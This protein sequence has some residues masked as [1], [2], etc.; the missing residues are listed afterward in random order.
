V[1]ELRID[2][3]FP[4]T[5]SFVRVDRLAFAIRWTREHTISLLV[6]HRVEQLVNEAQKNVAGVQITFADRGGMTR[7]LELRMTNEAKVTDWVIGLEALLAVVPRS[8]TKSHWQWALLCMVPTSERGSKDFIPRSN[9]RLVLARAHARNSLNTRVLEEAYRAAE[10]RNAE[11]PRWLRATRHGEGRRQKLLDVWQVT[12][13]LIELCTQSQQINEL[14]DRHAV[15]NVG[16]LKW[17]EF[18]RAEQVRG[19]VDEIQSDVGKRNE[20][21]ILKAKRV[22]PLSRLD[23]ALL[24]L[25]PDNDAVV[26]EL[27]PETADEQDA[28]LAHYW[29]ACSHNSYLV[30]DQLTGLS[31]ADAYRRQLLQRCRSLEIDCWD[32]RHGPIVTHGHTFCTV[33]KFEE[34]AKAIGECAFITSDLPVILSMEMHC[35]PEQQGQLTEMLLEHVGDRILP[36]GELTVAGRA[37]SLS[38]KELKLRVLVKGKIKLQKNQTSSRRSSSSS[39]LSEKMPSLRRST[40]TNSRKQSVEA[41]AFAAKHKIEKVLAKS[42]HFVTNAQYANII[43]LQSVPVPVFLGEV[44][45]DDA[46]WPITSMNEN[47]WL[48]ALGLTQA[49]CNQIMGLQARGS[50][51]VPA[52]QV[53]PDAQL[54]LARDPSARVGAMQRRCSERLLRLYP[55]GLRFSGVNMNPLAGWLGGAQHIALNMSNVDVALQ[56]HFAL[57]KGSAG[58]VLKPHDMR[59]AKSS[60]R[61]LSILQSYVAAAADEKLGGGCR[62]ESVMLTATCLS[63][64]QNVD[65]EEAALG[66]ARSRMQQGNQKTKRGPTTDCYWP[67]PRDRLHRTTITLLSLHGLP[68]RGEARPRYEGSRS[69]CH[70]FVPTLSGIAIAPDSLLP[71]SPACCISV[72]LHPIGGFCAISDVLPI[73]DT[74]ETELIVPAEEKNAMSILFGKKVYCIAAEPHTTFLRFAVTDGDEVVAYETAVLAKLR[75]G[76]RIVQLRSLLGTRIEI[77][78]LFVKIALVDEPNM[79]STA[80]QLLISTE[81]HQNELLTLKRKNLEDGQEIVKLREEVAQLR[82]THV[83]RSSGRLSTKAQSRVAPPI[84][85]QGTM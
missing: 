77:A 78:Y 63:A 31:S 60:S 68:K 26:S 22:Q 59:H 51:V 83:C 57:F 85:R 5:M 35:S 67:P 46:I 7:L 30:G 24:L 75:T 69:A 72:A 71:S 15:P 6:V 76:Y 49:E 23:F 81:Q 61:N 33:E 16:R 54:R 53:P 21:E 58:F 27:V 42:K 74:V 79:F 62:K 44:P 25:S 3:V 19:G 65:N 80:R 41:A 28:P 52:G 40:S 29:T 2:G 13:L 10:E 84:A 82:E 47:R 32:S 20:A 66:A 56:L 9:L 48:R 50:L 8:V 64:L 4:N 18:V 36:Y 14:F 37:L 34:V 11:L 12:G 73:P 55:L 70:K 38:L 1:A 45:H 39:S 17:H 43:A